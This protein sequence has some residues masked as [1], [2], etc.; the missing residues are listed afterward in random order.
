M[1][2]LT[3]SKLIK[4]L[5]ATLAF[6]AASASFAQDTDGDGVPDLSDNCLNVANP[7]QLDFDAD[8]FGNLC[9]SD[10]NND[11]VVNFLDFSQLA[12]AFQ[13]P[14][15]TFDLNGDG[16]VNFLDL[17]LFVP[18]FNSTPGPNA[19]GA[20]FAANV[21]PILTTKCVPCHSGLGFGGHNMATVYGDSLN[22]AAHPTCPG[23]TV[24]ACALVR[25]RAGE[26]PPGAGCTG[27]PVTDAGNV[28]CMNY[29]EQTLL[30][31]W[32]NGGLAP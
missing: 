32:I 10:F 2:T 28:S 24:G 7:A 31:S 8:L 9:D 22:A 5:A 18:N 25:V 12:A 27:N 15:P 11:G 30:S 20:S 23:L 16:I 13:T 4:I 1:N 29:A 19:T 21:Q 17:A 3:C 14:N 26:M 6:F